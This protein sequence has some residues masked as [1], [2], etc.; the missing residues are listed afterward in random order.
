M[1]RLLLLFHHCLKFY[2]F[3]FGYILS[4]QPCIAYR[5]T[6]R[7][8]EMLS[9]H[10]VSSLLDNYRDGQEQYHVQYIYPVL[11]NSTIFRI[12]NVDYQIECTPLNIYIAPAI[13]YSGVLSG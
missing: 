8:N 4:Y 2:P 7:R 6:V 1:Y 5:S 11:W 12:G 10:L 3:V 13:S 9:N